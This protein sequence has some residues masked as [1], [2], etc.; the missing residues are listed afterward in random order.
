MVAVTPT[1][2]LDRLRAR[3]VDLDRVVV[4]FSGGADSAL[5]AWVAHDTLGPRARAAT[6]VSASL[7]AD[8][9]RSCAELAAEWGLAWE[10][11]VTDE[12]DNPAY[13]R[14]D[15]DR[16]YWCKDA[17]LAA[18][19]PLADPVGAT[20]CL[21]VNV[22]DLDDHRPGQRAA[23]ER[24]AAFPLVDAGFT[25]ARVRQVSRELGLP[26]W[27]KPAAACLASRLPYGTEVTLGRLASVERAEAALRALGFVEL[28][29][30]HHGDVAR[31]EVPELDLDAVVAKREAVVEA[32]QSAGYRWA[33][34]DLAGL[35]SGGF[36]QLLR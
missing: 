26:T 3:L 14:N 35:R 13:A 22:D 10:E 34:L 32:V 15:G 2:E 21:G 17:L 16:C 24:G 18:L 1:P 23:A 27:D 6:A 30:R 9:R 31:I 28:R 5:L 29:V 36:N 20:V 25:K 33:A 4:A 7:P 12:L 8:E 19:L 11:V